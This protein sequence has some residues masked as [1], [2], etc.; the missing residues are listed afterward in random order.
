VDLP[1][2]QKAVELYRGDYLPESLYEPW[3][4]EERERLASTFLELADRLTEMYI[5]QGQYAEAIDLSQRVLT[6]DKCWERAYRHLMLAYERL[7]DRGQIGR[8]YQRCA[9]ALRDELDV[10]PSPE[11]QELYEKLTS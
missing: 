8:T 3:L 7:G 4:A 5:A 6:R 2:L 9:Q 10:S 11:T 1:Q